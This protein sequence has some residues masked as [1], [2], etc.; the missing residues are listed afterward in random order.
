MSNLTSVFMTELLVEKG[1]NLGAVA[2]IN[3]EV[4]KS[5]A[6]ASFSD[7]KHEVEVLPELLLE[8]L[9]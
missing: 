3:A 7:V 2:R 8:W 6:H 9:R 1:L 5:L 4:W